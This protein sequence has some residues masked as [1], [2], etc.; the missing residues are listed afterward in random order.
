[1][2]ATG[3]V[4]AGNETIQRTLLKLAEDGSNHARGGDRHRSVALERRD[5]GDSEFANAP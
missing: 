4:V 5:R 1:M 2:L 3:S